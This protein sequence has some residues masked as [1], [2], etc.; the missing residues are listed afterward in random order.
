MEKNSVTEQAHR[1][2]EFELT[3]LP[4]LRKIL[5]SRWPQW[6]LIVILLAVF[7]YAIAAGIFGTQV[8]NQNAAITLVWIAWWA[9]LMLL[10]V[11]FGGRA[12]CSICPIPAPGEWIQRGGVFQPDGTQR[13]GLGR[14]WPRRLRNMWLQNFGFVGMALFSTVILTTPSVSA[15]VLLALILLAVGVSII[16]ERRTF[17]R[18]LCPVGG[19]IGLYSLVSPLAVRVK[20]P[21][22]CRSHPTKDCYHGNEQGH[23]C[24]WMVFPGTLDRSSNC[25]M[26]LECLRTCPLDNV[27][28][29]IQKPAVDLKP[30]RGR[31]P[32]SMDEAYKGFI[33]L[34]SALTYSFV[35]LGPWGNLK[36]AA[37][38]V[39]TSAWLLYAAGFILLALGLIPGAFAL[40]AWLGGWLAGF[41]STPFRP[42]FLESITGLVPLG[43]AY[44]VA[45]SLSF[46]M[47]NG[48]YVLATL[49]DPLGWG[50]NLFGTA[51]IAWQP[52][53]S[54]SLP[55]IQAIILL[56]GLAWAVHLTI[57]GVAKGEK[58][59]P[60]LFLKTAPSLAVKIGLTTALMGFYL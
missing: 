36:L 1:R 51:N 27:A 25:G 50:W 22:I 17:C 32:L 56:A 57:K 26:C 30:K 10:L 18:Y 46:A 6:V 41:R 7:V 19:F 39:G 38:S 4:W 59:S 44:W 23:G 16:F 60:R 9:L 34:A 20:D 24:P 45:F 5:L 55:K 49:S 42:R 52:I 53:F 12:W 29:V 13:K 33:M 47:I 3:S 58:L 15:W 31:A 40:A 43:L 21:E 11:P 14:R 35:L 8:G 37:Y 48:S 54:G 2:F 28:V